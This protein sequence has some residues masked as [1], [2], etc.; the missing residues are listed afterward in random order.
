MAGEKYEEGL[1]AAIEE[2]HR[3][4]PDMPMSATENEANSGG[5]SVQIASIHALFDQ[6][7]QFGNSR[8]QNSW[9][10]VGYPYWS[11]ARLSPTQRSRGLARNT[12]ID[13]LIEKTIEVTTV[14]SPGFSFA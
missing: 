9:D 13:S 8:R 1:R 10:G 5:V 2:V 3:V 11:A 4:F 7:G 14:I 12:D 6:A